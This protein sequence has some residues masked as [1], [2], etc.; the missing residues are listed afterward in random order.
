MLNSKNF[1]TMLL[2]LLVGSAITFGAIKYFSEGNSNSR[3]GELFTVPAKYDI[4]TV[5][6]PNF[7]F[8]DVSEMVMQTVVHIKTTMSSTEEEDPFRKRYLDD[9]PIEGSGSGVIISGDGYIVTNNH[10]VNGATKIEVVLNDKRSYVGDV[11]GTDPNTDMALIKIEATQLVPIKIGNSNDVKVGQWVLAVGNPFNLTSTVTAGIVSAKGRN[12]RLLGGGTAIESFIQT[13]AAV[14]PGNSGG[15]LVN[16]K[17][18]LVGI[19]T[20]IAS[21]TG[22]FAGYSFAVPANLMK[23]VIEDIK[24]YGEVQRGFIGVQIDD[25]DDKIAKEKSLDK[26]KGVLVREIQDNGAADEAGMK[27]GDIIDMI[28]D[29]SVNSVAELQE[30]IGSHRPGDV[31]KISA[32]RNGKELLFNIKLRG[33]DN[34]STLNTTK[35]EFKKKVQ[36]TTEPINEE[37]KR[38]YKLGNGVK[39]VKIEGT[40][41]ENAGIKKGYIIVS[42]DKQRVFTNADIYKILEDKKGGILMEVYN[43]EG[44]KEYKVIEMD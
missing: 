36:I 41:F 35:S 37:L 43:N 34:S 30:V 23:K 22:S 28:D 10:V 4:K 14:N 33:K 6:V 20:A 24:K 44:K 17:G 29:V 25:V 9:G 21:Q 1:W 31:L 42:L 27:K 19:N 32:F 38:K 5:T 7:D 13:D 3:S 39:V 26:P 16:V 15:A 2:A 11:I 12:I 40:A 8:T 18:E